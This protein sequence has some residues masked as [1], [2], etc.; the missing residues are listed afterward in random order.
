MEINA[1]GPCRFKL[2]AGA[3]MRA[4]A[5]HLGCLAAAVALAG[6]AELLPK[7]ET[8]VSNPWH[9]YEQ[10]KAAIERIVP[11]QTT[12]RELK[13]R[14]FDPFVTQNVQLLNYSDIVLRFPISG[15]MPMD[16]LD[17]GLRE[18][19][20]AGKECT[21]YAIAVRET[22]RDRVG[23]FW[24]DA[25]NFHRVTDVTGWSFNALVLVVGGR[26]VYVTWGGQPMIREQE[27]TRQPLGPLQGWGEALP[28]IVR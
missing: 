13:E 23:N 16:R 25:L 10:A 26:A 24:A 14:G 11:Y 2:V 27:M 15:S 6:C 1:A 17:R 9:S 8:V 21:G 12:T 19:L 7:A 3:P 20:E 28:G 22:K 4:C 18:C 5:S